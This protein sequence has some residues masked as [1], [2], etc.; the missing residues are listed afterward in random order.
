MWID[1]QDF[2]SDIIIEKKAFERLLDDSVAIGM[3]KAVQVLVN[4][5]EFLLISLQLQTDY[6][7]T[8]KNAVFDF[9]P[10][11]ACEAVISCLDAHTKVLTGCIEK[12]TMEVFQ[13]EVSVRMFQY[14]L[15]ILE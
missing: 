11:K 9:K 7:P 12:S 3:D 6:N 2:L 10:T 4:Q 15:L 8:Q 14:F 13:S 5:C 1:E